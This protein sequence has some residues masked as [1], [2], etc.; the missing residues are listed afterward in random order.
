MGDGGYRYMV[1]FLPPAGS[2]SSSFLLPPTQVGYGK[3]H[4]RERKQRP[5]GLGVGWGIRVCGATF[6]A[7]GF[8]CCCWVWWGGLSCYC[9]F[10]LL[11]LLLFLP[12]LLPL[13]NTGLC[14]V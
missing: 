7:G 5:P 13:P 12:L 8:C 10:L 1:W 3:P 6:T 2:S 14:L 11:L 9:I 4:K